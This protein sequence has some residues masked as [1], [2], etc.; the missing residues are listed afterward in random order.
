MADPDDAPETAELVSEAWIAAALPLI[1][2]VAMRLCRQLGPS[3][4]LDDLRSIGHFALMDLLRRYDPERSPLE[5]Y[6]RTRLRWAMLDGLRR[7]TRYR[8]LAGRVRALTAS[9]DLASGWAQGDARREPTH[10]QRLAAML[11]E[12][13][14][15]LGLSLLVEH[16]VE[17]AVAPSSANPERM[18]IKHALVEKVRAALGELGDARQREIIERYYFRGQAMTALARDMGI[19]KGYA[20]KLHAK[21]IAALER[22]LRA[23]G[24]TSSLR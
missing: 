5:A 10:R 17:I 4:D 12:H 2:V 15:C 9:M 23:G 3:V 14:L 21:A 22:A 7:D 6:L 11:R 16:H 13:A 24:V 1:D 20:S 19:T 8:P 18:S